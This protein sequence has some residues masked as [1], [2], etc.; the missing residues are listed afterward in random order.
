MTAEQRKKNATEAGKVG[1]KARAAKLTLR[2]G[3]KAPRPRQSHGGRKTRRP[4]EIHLGAM[5][6]CA[7]VAGY[8]LVLANTPNEHWSVLLRG[9]GWFP[10]ALNEVYASLY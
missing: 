1:G 3:R 8:E 10:T 2:S 6:L 9:T 5:I 4:N 7:E